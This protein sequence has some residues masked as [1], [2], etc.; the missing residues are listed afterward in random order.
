MSTLD[1]PR[2]RAS[3]STY[4]RLISPWSSG[5][6]GRDL[7]RRCTAPLPSAVPSSSTSSAQEAAG[8]VGAMVSLSSS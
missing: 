7:A 1:S 4:T 3:G 8:S 6:P 5:A 2:P